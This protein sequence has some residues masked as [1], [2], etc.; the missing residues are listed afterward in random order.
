M[1]FSTNVQLP[2]SRQRIREYMKNWIR[3]LPGEFNT[4]GGPRELRVF[5]SEG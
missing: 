3:V 4:G 5:L 1:V 2:G